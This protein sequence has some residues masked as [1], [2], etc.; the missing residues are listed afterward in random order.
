M[1]RGEIS[2]SVRAMS[3]YYAYGVNIDTA[4]VEASRERRVSVKREKGQDKAGSPECDENRDGMGDDIS[5]S[6]AKCL[7]L[8]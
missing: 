1:G 2:K 6:G 7:E 8:N 3:T 5:R 4:K